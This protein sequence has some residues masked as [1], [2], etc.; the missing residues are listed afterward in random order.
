MA[1]VVTV[2]WEGACAGERHVVWGPRCGLEHAWAGEDTMSHVPA[3]WGGG[4]MCGRGREKQGA[5]GGIS[6]GSTL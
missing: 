4:Q 1:Y 3:T 6:Q 5:G 2:P